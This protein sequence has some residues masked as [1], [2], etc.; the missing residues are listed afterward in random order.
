MPRV[1]ACVRGLERIR[2]EVARAIGQGDDDVRHVRAVRDGRRLDPR[3]GRRRCWPGPTG[4]PRRSRRWRPGSRCRSPSGVRSSGCAGRPESATLS[5]VG[6]WTTWAKP[7]NA[8]IPI[9]VPEP[10][11]SMNEAA[12]DSA[13]WSRVGAMSSEHML[14]DTSMTSTIVVWLVGTLAIAIGR[15]I[16][17]AQG[18]QRHREQ[19]ERE[20]P[21]QP[22]GAGLR[23]MDER[24]A[25]IADAGRPPATQA[26]D[27]DADQ[28]RHGGE[29]EQEARPQEGHGRRPSQASDAMA[30]ASSSARPAP[31]RTAVSSMSSGR[32]TSAVSRCW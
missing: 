15:P 31:A 3:A 19:R 12:A 22:S 14:P 10:W 6:D 2:P 11:C 23:R 16:A 17:E 18:G 30:P 27:V 24:E 20:V 7:L 25:R 28:Q 5:L 8:T 26:P 9:W 13:A 1:A 29:E 32:T 4:R 21:S